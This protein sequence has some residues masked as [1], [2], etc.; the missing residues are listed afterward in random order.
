LSKNLALLALSCSS[1]FAARSA[2]ERTLF[3]VGAFLCLR[4]RCFAEFIVEVELSE[5]ASEDICLLDL[6]N[7]ENI[8]EKRVV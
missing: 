3:S 2:S 4:R 5:A 7:L 6:E 8:V 1:I